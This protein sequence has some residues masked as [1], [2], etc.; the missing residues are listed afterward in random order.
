VRG[1]FVAALGHP[2]VASTNTN[3]LLH[4]FLAAG[5]YNL[6]TFGQ[7]TERDTMLNITVLQDSV[8]TANFRVGRTDGIVEESSLNPIVHNHVAYPDTLRIRNEGAGLLDYTVV[9]V[10]LDPP[11]PWMRPA[12]AAGSI[13]AGDS[14]RV[15][16]WIQADTSNSGTFDYYGRIDVHMNSCPDSVQ[17]VSVLA[18][19]LDAEP[20]AAKPLSFSLSA[21]PNPFNPTTALSFDLPRAE[22]ATLTIFDITGR[23]VGTL[24]DGFTP[25]GSHR[26]LFDGHALASG[27]YIARLQTASRTLSQKLMLLK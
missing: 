2:Y 6:I 26:V 24:I 4:A 27:L 22:N 16:I 10:P 7:C 18:G 23:T 1:A 21:S 14:T 12:P 19:V 13:P 20:T 25:A 3:G 11:T 5:T 17:H 8:A 9:C 15:V